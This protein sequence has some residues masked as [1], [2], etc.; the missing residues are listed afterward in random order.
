[1]RVTK[2]QVEWI[3]KKLDEDLI[4]FSFLA[5]G[6]HNDNYV[7]ETDDRKYV[8]RIENNP[9]FK[10][11]KKE[12]NLLKSLKPELG[13]K[14]FFLDKSH[15]II[16]ADYFV[17]EFVVG[18]HPTKSDEKFIILMAKWLKKLHNQK[19]K[20]K[21]YSLLPAIKPYYNN[22]RNHKTALSN[23]ISQNLDLLFD[24]VLAFCR[25]KN[26]VFK[27]RK[28]NSLLHRDLSKDN[29]IYDGKKIIL[30]DWEFSDYNFLEW[31]LVYF[32][33]SQKLN[34]RLK[35]LFLKSYGYSTTSSNKKKLLVI[36]L[37]N[38]CGNVGYSI[39]RLDLIKQGKLK[40]TEK[41]A[42]LRRLKQ[43]LKLLRNIINNLER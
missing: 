5:R 15:K 13:P 26:N 28:T 10:N 12:Y 29:I 41:P 4:R 25:R 3:C 19:K 21:K 17:E 24:R 30:L 39:W 37:L 27:N 9:Q 40:K 38:T 8:L 2:R 11:L 16:S 6:N 34:E 35:N 43:D 36:S 18:K 1:M 14:V 42:I 7:I 22:F 32:I 23:E 20:C 33:E 31:D